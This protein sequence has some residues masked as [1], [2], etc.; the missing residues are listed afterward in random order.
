MSIPVPLEG[1]GGGGGASLNFDVKAYAT[2]EALLAAVPKE[3]TIGVITQTAIT[4]WAFS[5]TEP[6]EPVA[7]MV[8]ISTGDS[9]G[10]AF[11]ALKKNAIQV[12]PLFAKQY[13]NGAWVDVTAYSYRGGEWVGWITYIAINENDWYKRNPYPHV[14]YSYGTYDFSENSLKGK[15]TGPN[16]QVSLVK[17]EKVDFSAISKV[18]FVY[19]LDT[20]LGNSGQILAIVS[21]SDNDAS[22]NS[23][24]C[25]KLIFDKA[26]KQTAYLDVSG[27]SGQHYLWIGLACW[28]NHSGTANFE[29]SNLEFV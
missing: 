19:S 4:S 27:V 6:A 28:E 5:A 11:N 21:T 10:V 13:V 12:Y 24:I 22:S 2:E 1:F 3:N 20:N 9:S 16:Q 15:V 23:S 14:S 17:K 29:I 7:G 18:K 8:W 26:T 25:T